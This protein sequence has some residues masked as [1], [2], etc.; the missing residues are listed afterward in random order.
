[1]HVSTETF[2]TLPQLKFPAE[3]IPKKCKQKD[4]A[5]YKD[6]FPKDFKGT[7]ISDILLIAWF[8]GLSYKI[9]EHERGVI[10]LEKGQKSDYLKL[11]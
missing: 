2:V 9:Y 7:R 6:K 8:H 10:F 5:V 11:L 1:M 3:K 4:T